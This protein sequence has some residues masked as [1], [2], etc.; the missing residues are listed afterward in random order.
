[1]YYCLFGGAKRGVTPSTEEERVNPLV[2]TV[3]DGA[4][5]AVALVAL[6]LAL[7]AVI[8]LI[9]AAPPSG[10]RLLAWAVVVLIVPVV[11]PAMWFRARQR[12]RS[13]KHPQA[14]DGT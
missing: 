6:L 12:A 9:R 1:M 2:P 10:W 7:A 8:S 11:G 3:L 4:L 5:T 13:V 14:G